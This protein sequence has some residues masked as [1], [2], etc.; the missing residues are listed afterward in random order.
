MNKIKKFVDKNK[1]ALGTG[2]ELAR[3]YLKALED[4]D[5]ANR[6]LM[7][8]VGFE[9]FS[10]KLLPYFQADYEKPLLAEA[11]AERKI[12]EME[13]DIKQLL[14]IGKDPKKT[15]KSI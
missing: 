5:S 12:A 13:A 6:D 7:E 3:A 4:R 1:S 14:E 2:G 10:G 15:R 9:E 11:A 8:H